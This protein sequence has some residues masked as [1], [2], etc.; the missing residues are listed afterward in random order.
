MKAKCTW[1]Y[2]L[3]LISA[4]FLFVSGLFALRIGGYLFFIN[5]VDFS[6]LNSSYIERYS[7][8]KYDISYYYTYSTF[9]ILTTVT[10]IFF[11]QAKNSKQASIFSLVFSIVTFLFSLILV[12]GSMDDISVFYVDENFEEQL[13]AQKIFYY[14]LGLSLFIFLFSLIG[15]IKLICVHNKNKKL[16][17]TAEETPVALSTVQPTVESSNV[18]SQE[19]TEVT[20]S[21]VSTTDYGEKI[22][23]ADIKF[24]DVIIGEKE[25]KTFKKTAE[26]EELVPLA[27]G[28]KLMTRGAKFFVKALISVLGTLLSIIVGISSLGGDNGV[29]GIAIIV[30][31]YLFFNG[32]AVK[33]TSYTSTYKDCYK[34]LNKENKAYV[35][36]FAKE[37]AAVAFFKSL[38]ELF[39]TFFTLPYRAILMLIGT[40]IP[41][42]EDWCIAHGGIGGTVVTLP[43][44]Y[45]I[46]G[47]RE[48]GAYYK[49]RQF[50]D[51][52]MEDTR[53][54]KAEKRSKIKTY[55]YEDET[56]VMQ[57][58][59][60]TDDKK[61]YSSEEMYNKVGES[62]DGG[63]TIDLTKK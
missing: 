4:T 33:L 5:A 60:T 3:L 39:L 52:F 48:V 27:I 7:Y 51:A 29:F 49:S 8:S 31:G 1:A 2:V 53:R 21:E 32:L 16:A 26:Q 10:F 56:G 6:E 9:I 42:T 19:K 50:L 13:N 34:K 17:A 45:D 61:F 24:E 14:F 62:N 15:S 11:I 25:W 54:K 63:E 43:E 20:E 23:F 59:Y 12:F 30:G 22:A 40:L 57:K 47:L 58:T 36:D 18:D 41:S 28:A 38:V 55:E 37:N 35:A 44:G 46:G